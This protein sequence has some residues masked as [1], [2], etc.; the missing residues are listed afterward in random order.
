VRNAVRQNRNQLLYSRTY[1]CPFTQAKKGRGKKTFSGGHALGSSVMIFGR[2]KTVL[3][4]T[5]AAS[6]AALLARTHRGYRD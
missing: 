1:A 3:A 2:K 6:A 5:R 4:I